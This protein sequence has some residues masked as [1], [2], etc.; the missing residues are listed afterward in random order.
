[1]RTPS[2]LRKMIGIVAEKLAVITPRFDKIV[3]VLSR[4][5]RNQELFWSGAN[6]FWN[7]HKRRT[8]TGKLA[9]SNLRELEE[10]GLDV[11]GLNHADSGFIIS[12]YLKSF[13]QKKPGQDYLTRMIYS[14]FR[15]RLPELLLM[16]IDKIGMS[17]SIE[18]RVPFL[19]HKLVE[20]T[21]DI[22]MRW[23]IKDGETKYL[24]KKAL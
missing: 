24:L 22:P 7:V 19:D 4:A 1:M 21:M 12:S 9:P 23:K 5:G 17:T 15:L 14:E 8:L 3:E 10:A 2:I 16:R 13:D 18:A 6:A 11:S 20:F